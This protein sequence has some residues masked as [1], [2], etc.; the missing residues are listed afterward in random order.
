MVLPEQRVAPGEQAA[1][2]PATQVAI[3][4]HAAPDCHWP[5][6]SQVCGVLL[7]HCFAPGKHSPVHDPAEQTNAQS[8]PFVHCPDELQ[9]CGVL[10]LHC[11][12][13]GAHI[14]VQVPPLQT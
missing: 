6:A 10:P 4:P 12:V 5:F 9:V 14:P 3:A 8:V 1:H 11:F 7:E 13:P 2:A